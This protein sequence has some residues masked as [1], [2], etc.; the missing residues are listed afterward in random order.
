MLR[1]VQQ[2][3]S[4]QRFGSGCAVSG[5]QL[6]ADS[7]HLHTGVGEIHPCARSHWS[8]RAQNFSS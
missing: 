8:G 1:N 2:D 3:T 7:R 5:G 4:A 6:G